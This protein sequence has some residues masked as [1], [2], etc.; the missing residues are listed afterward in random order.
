[1]NDSLLRRCLKHCISQERNWACPKVPS[2]WEPGFL[3]YYSNVSFKAS[4]KWYFGW[5]ICMDFAGWL[6]FDDQHLFPIF[7]AWESMQSCHTMSVSKSLSLKD[8]L[9]LKV[10]FTGIYHLR[11]SKSIT[12]SIFVV[13]QLRIL[14]SFADFPALQCPW[15]PYLISG[16]G[17]KLILFTFS[18]Q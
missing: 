18:P 15:K 16:K 12:V 3:V 13:S 1:M 10:T 2:A 11:Q 4:S 9:I 6:P 5:S 17:Q 8:N 14:L 7:D